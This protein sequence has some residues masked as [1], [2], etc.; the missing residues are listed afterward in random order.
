MEG[1]YVLGLWDEACV[2]IFDKGLDNKGEKQ[3]MVS[4]RRF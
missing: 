2:S 3:E 4:K 1:E